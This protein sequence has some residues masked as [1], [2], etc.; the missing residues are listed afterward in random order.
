MANIPT[1]LLILQRLQALLSTIT[2]IGLDDPVDMA[3]KVFRGRI[4]LGADVKPLPVIS[5]LEAP[6]PDAAA[7]H[8]G[9][10]DDIRYDGW[11]LLIQG[12]IEDD[13]LT[14]T[15]KAYYLQAAVEAKL[16]EITAVNEIGNPAYPDAFY[17]GGLIT[18][19][20]IGPP[21]VRPPENQVSAT[22][23]FF[24]PVRVGVVG[25]PGK[26]YTAV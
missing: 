7:S 6:R 16:A 5:I 10:W 15:D 8:S 26:P 12:M 11:T 25:D 14:P 22:G 19:F 1:R 3:D 2:D 24:L 4:L 9:D 21:V 18:K 20:E 17:L 23:F 13:I